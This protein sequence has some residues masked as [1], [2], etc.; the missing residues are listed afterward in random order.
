MN[1]LLLGKAYKENSVI[2]SVFGRA[3]LTYYF[4]KRG[5]ELPQNA[6]VGYGTENMVQFLKNGE[7]V[8]DIDITDEDLLNYDTIYLFFKYKSD[9]DIIEENYDLVEFNEEMRLCIYEKKQNKK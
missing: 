6:V 3:Y 9:S 5:Y 8:E 4:E 7:I 1:L 2:V